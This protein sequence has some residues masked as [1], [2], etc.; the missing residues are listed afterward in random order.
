VVIGD[1]ATHHKKYDA[2]LES[3]IDSVAGTVSGWL[4]RTADVADL[5]T[6]AREAIT[7][8]C[9][10]RHIASLILPADVSWTE[11]AGAAKTVAVQ[12]P[13][14][15]TDTAAADPHEQIAN[16]LAATSE[17]ASQAAPGINRAA[18]LMPFL[19]GDCWW[20][21]AREGLAVPAHHVTQ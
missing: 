5:A 10:H 13:R 19:D 15:T 1:H 14:P 11:G 16:P 4:R 6:D 18:Q 9:A 7:S 8:A 21:E 20:I 17:G 12:S 2:P 3:D